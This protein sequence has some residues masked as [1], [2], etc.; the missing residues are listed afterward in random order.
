MH[1]IWGQIECEDDSSASAS[2]RR[3]EGTRE[4]AQ[5]GVEFLSDHTPTEPSSEAQDSLNARED[6]TKRPQDEGAGMPDTDD[7]EDDEQAEGKFSWSAGSELHSKGKCRPCSYVGRQ[8]GCMNGESCEFCHMY[9]PSRN[10]P[11]KAKRNR[12]KRLVSV[13]DSVDFG[14]RDQ[15]TQ[16]VTTLS[17]TN[18]YMKNLVK[19][20]L[21]DHLSANP[22]VQLGV[23]LAEGISQTRNAA[24]GD[25]ITSL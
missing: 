1:R 11:R 6:P 9:H 18:E 25:L 20:R 12:C 10:R 21:R 24:D 13:L 19:G 23:D 4:A 15:L 8:I 2:R 17:G 14:D 7:S 5:T 22:G 16:V 3:H